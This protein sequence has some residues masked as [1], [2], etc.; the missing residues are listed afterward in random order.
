MRSVSKLL[1][2]FLLSTVTLVSQSGPSPGSFSNDEHPWAGFPYDPIPPCGWG[3]DSASCLFTIGND[4][5]NFSDPSGLC[6]QAGFVGGPGQFRDP[7]SGV[8]R[9]SSGN[10]IRDQLNP[11]NPANFEEENSLLRGAEEVV[12]AAMRPVWPQTAKEMSAFLQVEGTPIPDTAATPG[13]SKTV[14]SLGPVK[15][16]LEQHPYHPNAPAWH[17]DPHWHLDLP[18][19]P[20]LRYVPGDPIPGF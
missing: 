1:W 9:D 8:V 10:P 12:A 11:L 20:H 5:I 18:G 13:R 19:N 14:W 17:R 15:I 16:T 4:P 2:V 3:S 7:N 6:Q